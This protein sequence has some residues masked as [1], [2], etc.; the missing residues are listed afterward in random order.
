MTTPQLR[1]QVATREENS[2]LLSCLT[3]ILPKLY[4]DVK[5]L[6]IELMLLLNPEEVSLL[7]EMSKP[8]SFR[9]DRLNRKK[10]KRLLRNKSRRKGR[11][12]KMRGTSRNHLRIIGQV[13]KMQCETNSILRGMKISQVSRVPSQHLS[14]LFTTI[15]KD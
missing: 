10:F 13:Q 14:S 9:K 2:Y 8:Y 7:E 11:G 12:K 15:L 4:K 1:L 5:K 3:I 6:N